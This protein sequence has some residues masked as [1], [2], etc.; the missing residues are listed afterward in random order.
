MPVLAREKP[1][2][3]E[4]KRKK[5]AAVQGYSEKARHRQ[6]QAWIKTSWMA[7]LTIGLLWSVAGFADDVQS[8]KTDDELL[9]VVTLSVET[10]LA[11]SE[12]P[13]RWRLVHPTEATAY[14]DGWLRP[15]ADFDFQDA[16]LLSRASKLRGLALLTLA[17]FGQTRLFL[18]V[19]EEGLVGLHID[20]FPQYVGDRYLEIVRMPYLKKTSRAAE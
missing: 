15:I 19:N 1:H 14:S 3:R 13:S 10:M 11:E 5:A 7:L 4:H 9:P 17:E 6:C 16:G 20:V 2:K 12:Y 18:G 8:P